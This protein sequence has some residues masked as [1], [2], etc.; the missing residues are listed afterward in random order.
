MLVAVG[1]M[2]EFTTLSLLLIMFDSFQHKVKGKLQT[3]NHQIVNTV[4]AV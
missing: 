2:S 3:V 1:Y 4:C